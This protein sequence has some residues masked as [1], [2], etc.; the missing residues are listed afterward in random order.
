MTPTRTQCA[1]GWTL[2]SLRETEARLVTL[3]ALCEIDDS[4][5]FRAEMVK[6]VHTWLQNVRNHINEVLT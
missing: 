5:P 3:V 2:R 1:H 4:H 6:G